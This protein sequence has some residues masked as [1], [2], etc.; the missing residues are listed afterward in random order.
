MKR[1]I[2]TLLGLLCLVAIAWGLNALLAQR[3]GQLSH[4]A[5]GKD[6]GTRP[7]PESKA[8]PVET[9]ELIP[10]DSLETV[11]TFTGHVTARQS[12][13]LA[14]EGTGAIVELL[15]QEGEA[16]QAGQVLGRLNT[17]LLQAQRSEIE[18]RRV[19][20]EAQ[21]DELLRGPREE[22]IEAARAQVTAMKEKLDLAR[23]QRD[24]R[25][26]L[27]AKGTISSELLDTTRAEV[28]QMQAQVAGAEANLAE[29]ENGTREEALAAQ[30]GALLELD[31]AL[32][33]VDVAISQTVLKAP[34]AG[35]IAARYLDLG[36]VVSVQVPTAAYRL[37]ETGA[38][39][40]YVGVPAS[41]GI[42]A[43]AEGSEPARLIL[44]GRSVLTTGS[45]T[46]PSVDPG[47]RTVTI[48][49]DLEPESARAAGA[50]PGDVISL[51]RTTTRTESGAWIPLT[52]L[53]E[54]ERGLWSALAV[55][56]PTD[57]NGPATAQRIELEVLTVTE[58]RA[59]VRGTFSGKTRIVASGV[60]RLV[61]GQRIR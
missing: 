36:A 25:Q 32:E 8:L 49:Y 21:L 44:R 1:I 48:I 33:S 39:E 53:S 7:G 11:A 6:T 3:L 52:A 40:A 47:T 5:A 17:S 4:Q 13:E 34:F 18:A 58:D 28:N 20:L 60:H 50:R 42:Q 54:S 56:A 59:F 31:A 29:L 19:R 10:T 55:V 16:V 51:E 30:R 15:A 38:L 9:F 27:A 22:S 14:F 2:P 43:A 37:V 24:R 12:A 61:P 35:T 41:L 46:L 23:M 57:G 45:R 26:E